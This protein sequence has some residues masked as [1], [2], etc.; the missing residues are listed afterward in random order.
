MLR[1]LS[2]HKKKEVAGGWIRLH[3]E[4]L[5]IM[6]LIKYYYCDC[7]GSGPVA[8]TCEFV[9]EPSCSILFGEFFD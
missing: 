4:E 9:N 2:G 7:S 5:Q 1:S 8:N 3:I 6:H